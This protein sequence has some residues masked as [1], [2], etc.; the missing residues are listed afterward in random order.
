MTTCPNRLLLPPPC[1]LLHPHLHPLHP[2]T[3]ARD[4]H[5]RLTQSEPSSY[6]ILL[7]SSRNYWS[8]LLQKLKPLTVDICQNFILCINFEFSKNKK[9]DK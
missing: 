5:L 7:P 6:M 2:P 9:Y 1:P 3:L 4:P 8:P